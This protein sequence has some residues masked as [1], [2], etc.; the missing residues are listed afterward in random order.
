MPGRQ[1]EYKNMEMQFNGL[2]KPNPKGKS[3]FASSLSNLS[4]QYNFSV[5]AIVLT[6]MKDDYSQT[7]WIKETL[8]GVVFA[9]AITGQLLMGYV[10][11]AFGRNKA[12][13]FTITLA[14]IGALL[15]AIAPWGDN[16]TVYSLIALFRFFLG[17]GVGGVYPLSAA[18]AAEESDSSNVQARNLRVA[19][20]FFW[21]IPGA[22]LP[23][24]MALIVYFIF[25]S[26]QAQWRVLLAIGAVPT[27]F[28]LYATVNQEENAEFREDQSTTFELL[29]QPGNWKKLIGTGGTWLIYDVVYY[30]TSLFSPTII[31]KIF[32]KH[33]T[34]PKQAWQNI[35]VSAAGIPAIMLGIYCQ[36]RFGTK[37]VQIAGFVFIGVVFMLLGVLWKP[38]D[39]SPY[40]V[41]GIYILLLFSLNWGPNITTF[42]LPA[43]VYQPKVR[44]TMNGASAALGKL[45]AVIGTFMYEPIAEEFGIPVLMIVAGTISLIGA[46]LTHFTIRH[47]SDATRLCYPRDVLYQ[48]ASVNDPEEEKEG[49][50]F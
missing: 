46:V 36:Q 16:W 27:I 42:I 10:G 23:Y 17:V 22:M 35:V 49:N 45:G 44:S 50:E 30:G 4:V 29:K 48:P 6:I 1:E 8:K 40:S 32:G 3:L 5:I 43:E 37:S 21:Q 20:V 38:L 18:K 47:D 28:I 34:I 24:V 13:S 26:S 33:E 11:D 25:P 9:G 14:G 2:K 12:L 19:K 15:S 31:V 7:A 39:N 41:F